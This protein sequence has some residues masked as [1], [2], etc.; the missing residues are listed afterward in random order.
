MRTPCLLT[1]ILL[2]APACTGSSPQDPARSAASKTTPGEAT[3]KAAPVAVTAP[4]TPP[5]TAPVAPPVTAPVTPP[6]TAPVSD[7][8]PADPVAVA[9]SGPAVEPPGDPAAVP[10]EGEAATVAVQAIAATPTTVTWREV[11]RPASATTFEPLTRGVLARSAGGYSDVDDSGALVLRPEIQAPP[12]P[13]LGSWPDNAWYVE[14]RS[15]I[16]PGDRSMTEIRDMRL[17][18]LRGKKRWVPQEYNGAQRF[19]DEGESV[20]IG[21]AGGLIV[22]QNGSLTRLSDNGSDPVL[23]LDRGGDLVGFFE[24]RSGRVYTV[25]EV[26]GA[27]YVQRDCADLE[28]VAREAKKLPLGTQWSFT[29]PVT[30]QQHSVSA[31]AEVRVDEG[32]QAHLLHHET[33]GWKLERVASA[34]SG[35]WPTKDGGLWTMI[36]AQLLHRDPGGAWREVALPAGATAVT[37]AMRNDYS[38]L[39]IAATVDNASVV[40]ATAANA[41][42]PAPAP[43]AP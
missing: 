39:W 7:A 24:T 30:R 2:S 1:V 32:P 23:G 4:V 16:L 34:P 29:Q 31:V 26:D 21:G 41:Q 12:S 43:A 33:G 27:L 11:A 17:M 20:Q 42:A 6:V 19:P 10:A 36:D 14:T 40:F 3:G 15:K 25:R 5:V 22:E 37:A 9:P 8:P 28:C 13:V 18:R 38:E 35:L